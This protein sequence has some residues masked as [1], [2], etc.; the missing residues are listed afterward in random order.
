[1]HK[2]PAFYFG[3]HYPA[4]LPSFITQLYYP[5]LLM[6]VIDILFAQHQNRMDMLF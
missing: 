6:L 3:Y 5:A 2:S 1:M 4:L